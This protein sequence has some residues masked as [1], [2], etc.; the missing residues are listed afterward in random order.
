MRHP[1]VVVQASGLPCGGPKPHGAFFF[2]AC[3]ERLP[4]RV[5]RIRALSLTFS[6]VVNRLRRAGPMRRSSQHTASPAHLAIYLNSAPS[7]QNAVDI[8]RG[9]WT[10]SL[11]EPLAG[12]TAGGMDL[13]HDP[14]IDWFVEGIGG[15]RG[16]SALELGPLEGAHTYMLER[17]GAAPIVAV[18]ANTRAYLKCLIV[19]ELLGLRQ[20]RFI[21]GNFL[22]YLRRNE[23]SFQ[24]GIACGV[25]YHMEDPA[26]LIA[27]L[28][29]RCSEHVFIWTHYYDAAIIHR[30]PAIGPRFSGSRAH[31]HA[32]FS[33][34]LYQQEYQETLRWAGFCGGSA[35]A[36]NWMTREDL[37]RC[38]DHFGFE[39]KAQA[40]IARPPEWSPCV[41]AETA[42]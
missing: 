42:G 35:P 23:E 34:T 28:A 6:N 36:S 15:V 29:Q 14:R 4:A 10:C 18:E 11:P 20:T 16:K 7:P 27:L 8:F 9:E 40:S 2:Q 17:R 39:V 41:I 24:L 33:H 5:D 21:A 38:L 1:T 37:L 26:E 22:E 30:N 12:V 3:L 19:K 25:L 31:D 32:G 13:F